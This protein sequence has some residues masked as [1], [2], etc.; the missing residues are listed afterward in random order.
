MS[1]YPYIDFDTK[2]FVYDQIQKRYDYTSKMIT[3]EKPEIWHS[4]IRPNT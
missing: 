3:E 4:V 2:S 1:M